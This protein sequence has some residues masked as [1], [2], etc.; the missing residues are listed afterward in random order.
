MPPDFPDHV[1]LV[2]PQENNIEDHFVA[3]YIGWRGNALPVGSLILHWRVE[4]GQSRPPGHLVEVAISTSAMPGPGWHW[5]EM[6]TG[7]SADHFP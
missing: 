5:S 1:V 6:F 3:H 7:T 4:R 2:D